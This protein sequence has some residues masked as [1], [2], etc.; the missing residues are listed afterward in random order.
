MKKTNSEIKKD[1]IS[2][3]IEKYASLFDVDIK[4]YQKKDLIDKL[5]IKIT[6]ELI[7]I[8][9]LIEMIKDYDDDL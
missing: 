9:K 4:K 5:D 6:K 8:R 3:N 7:N 1:I 2:N